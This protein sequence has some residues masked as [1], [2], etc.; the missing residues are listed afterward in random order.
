MP[1]LANRG[2]RLALLRRLQWPRLDTG[3]TGPGFIQGFHLLHLLG[4]LGREV[5]HFRGYW[6]R[7][8]KRVSGSHL[9]Y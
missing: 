1:V 9:K 7:I 4:L 5:V 6:G 2:E 8:L 3:A